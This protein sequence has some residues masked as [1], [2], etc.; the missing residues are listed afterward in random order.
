[1]VSDGVDGKV[2]V[3]RGQIVGVVIIW[4]SD[5]A[6]ERDLQWITVAIADLDFFKSSV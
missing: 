1:M 6:F 4:D 5:G 3:V 2:A